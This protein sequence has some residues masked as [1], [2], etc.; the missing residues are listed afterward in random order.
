MDFKQI[1]AF[2]NVVRYKSFS[3]AADAT[4]F[5]Q[6]TIST[7]IRNLEKELGVKLLDRKSRIVEMTPQ[8][9]K[10]YKYAVEMINA[11]AQA[12]DAL[13]DST[14]NIGGILEIQTSSIPA[15]TFLPD[16]LSGFRNT[17]PRIQYY[18][19]VSDT[20]TVID[21]ITERRG[22]VGFIGEKI[23]SSAVECTKVAVDKSVLIAP[24]DYNIPSSI[25]LAD[26][27]QYPFIWRETGSATRRTFEQ[28]ALRSGFEK[29]EFE[30]AALVDDMD[31][32]IRSVEA[33]LGVAIISEKVAAS[34]GGRVKVAEIEDFKEDRV[35]YMIN[36]KSTSYSPAAE[37]F[38]SYVK[39]VMKDK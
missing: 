8:G 25:N 36:L 4:F 39:T 5:T 1:E 26:A 23:N 34:I 21:N 16:L 7:H 18:V 15:V 27:I 17:H 33:G 29:E 14:E 22:E 37:A 10:F 38:S 35:F 13:N 31:T 3:K 12:F 19:S 20:Q 6:P 2:V 11:R 32:M 24:V 30:V 28:T 9:S